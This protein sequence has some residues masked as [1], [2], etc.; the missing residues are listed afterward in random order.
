MKSLKML[1]LALLAASALM[2]FAGTNS[3]SA[4]ELTCGPSLCLVN[5]VFHWAS[6][7][8]AVLDAPFGNVEC[9][10]TMAGHVTVPG[11]STTTAEVEL[12]EVNWSNCGADNYQTLRPGKLIIHTAETSNNHDGTVT[13]SGAEWTTE[14]VG[15]HCIFGT[16]ATDIG[17]LTG[18]AN[19]AGETSI[20]DIS[21]TI[22]RVGGRSGVFCG[23]SAPWTGSLKI[24]TPD[25]LNVD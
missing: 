11:S 8:K 22:P 18:S 2:A 20:L 16:N 12:T 10:M 17:R 19:M 5:A 23:S 1:G 7:G 24:D 14:H 13:W 21:A 6:K 9:E 3:A 15:T 4:T 25:A